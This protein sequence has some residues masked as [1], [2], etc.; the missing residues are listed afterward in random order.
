MFLYL[1]QL[2]ILDKF[3]GAKILHFAPEQKLSEVI[4]KYLPEIYIKADLFPAHEGIERIDMLDIPYSESTFDYVIANHVLE[5]V[6]DDLIA[7]K[8]IHRVL[9]PGG[10]AILQTPYS[11]VLEDTFEDAGITGEQARLHVYGQSDHVRLYGKNI[12]SRIST[13]GF[14]SRMVKHEQVLPHIDSS[15]YGVNVNEPL[16]LFEKS[17]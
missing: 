6:G 3:R 5:H 13:A 7:L 12:P 17:F 4:Q 10:Y 2:G 11:A 15:K 9:V 14:V 16:F 1:D 8:E